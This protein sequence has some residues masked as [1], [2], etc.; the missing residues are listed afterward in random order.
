MSGCPERHQQGL[1]ST[2][3]LETRRAGTS[4]F[5]QALG[6]YFLLQRVPNAQKGARRVSRRHLSLLNGG[7]RAVHVPA[8]FNPACGFS[9]H[10]TPSFFCMGQ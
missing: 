5:Y 7:K 8:V 4:E 6:K 3:I 1:G 2:L 10:D 9:S